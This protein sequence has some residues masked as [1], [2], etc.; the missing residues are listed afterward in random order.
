MMHAFRA[1][2]LDRTRTVEPWCRMT[3]V[4][5]PYLAKADAAF[6]HFSGPGGKCASIAIALRQRATLLCALP[7]LNGRH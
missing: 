4:V 3:I 5:V 6:A 7:R 2:A 1:C